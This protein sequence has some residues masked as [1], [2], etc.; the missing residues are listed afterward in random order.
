MDFRLTLVL[1]AA[2]AIGADIPDANY[3]RAPLPGLPPLSSLPA[4]S[5]LPDV[6]V[7]VGQH[8][9]NQSSGLKPTSRLAIVRYVDGEFAKAVQALPA[10]KNGF[11]IVVGKPLDEKGL[12]S[13]VTSKGAGV[14]SGSTVQITG[15]EFRVKEIVFQIN[16]GGKKKFHLGEH[17]QVGVG[18]TANPTTTGPAASSK[19]GGGA[20]LILDFGQPLPDLS[21][22]DLKQDLSAVLDFSKEHS[23]T[24][25]W[26]DTLPPQFK[27]GIKDRQAVVGMDHE[28]VIAAL[29]RPDHK[30]RERDPGG[31]E[32]EDWIYGS[33][34]AKTVFVTF[35]GDKVI[36]IKE[37]D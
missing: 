20:T 18:G 12:K 37:Y 32:T 15:I 13:A 3:F 10:G 6:F 28:M 7:A 2:L 9:A 33:P 11:K 1:A 17:V 25:N 16:G 22:D 24:V 19:E 31:E 8:G 26:V 36:R 30:V 29:G 4:S 34:P 27:Q 5:N 23:A 14:N 35:A 21:P